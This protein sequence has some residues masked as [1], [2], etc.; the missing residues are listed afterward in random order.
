MACAALVKWKAAVLI[1]SS[2]PARFGILDRRALWPKQ[3]FVEQ[4]LRSMRCTNDHFRAGK[5]DFL[6]P[7]EVLLHKFVA[8]KVKVI[9]ATA[10]VEKVCL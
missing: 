6:L 4:S 5:G 9:N 3:A 2:R 8:V 10:D 7:C 1:L